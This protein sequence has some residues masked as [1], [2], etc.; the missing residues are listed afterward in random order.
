GGLASAIALKRQLGFFNFTVRSSNLSKFWGRLNKN[1]GCSSDVPMSFYSLSTDLSD[2]KESHGYQKDI[3]EYWVHLAEK[4]DLYRHIS[5]NCKVVSVEWD[6][7][8]NQ[9]EVVTEDSATKNLTRSTANVV[10]SAIGILD[11]PRYAAIPGLELYKGHTFHSARWDHTVE[12]NGRRVGV[13]GNGS[14][15][16]QFVPRITEDPKVQVIHF[17]RSPNWFLPNLRKVYSS[18]KLFLLRNIPFMKRFHR[19]SVFLRLEL[20]HIILFSNVVPRSIL[21]LLLS[22]YIKYTAPQEYQQTLIPTFPPGCKR[23][24][25]DTGYLEAL[26]RHNLDLNWDGIERIVEDGHITLD[27][28]IFATGFAAD[29][30]PLPIRGKTQTIQEYYEKAG[31]PKAYLGTVVPGF[32]NFFVVYGPN[33]ATGHTSVIFTNEVQINYILQV[34]TPILKGN[35]LSLEVDAAATD[36]YNDKIHHS[37]SKSVFSQCVSWYRVGGEGKVSSA[38]PK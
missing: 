24:I 20:A 12:L 34:I 8:I 10:I 37:L 11:T 5:F 14:S 30:Y 38:F 32:P 18:L 9:Y 27:V 28:I 16:T 19:W 29:Y 7:A 23:V 22:Q 35:V 31:G 25:F 6:S 4:Y 15:A 13:I 1:Y 2:W 3:L 17:C 21:P 26:H 36:T 33:T